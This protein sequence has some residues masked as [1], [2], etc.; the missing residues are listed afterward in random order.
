M[1]PLP[2]SLRWAQRVFFRGPRKELRIFTS[3]V[4]LILVV[5]VRTFRDDGHIPSRGL[6]T[7]VEASAPAWD[8][9][10]FLV[11]PDPSTR[12]TC[13]SAHDYGP[14]QGRERER[15]LEAKMHENTRPHARTHAHTRAH[16]RAH[17]HIIAHVRAGG[18]VCTLTNQPTPHLSSHACARIYPVQP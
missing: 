13:D 3:I 1:R 7:T 15:P 5:T 4:M 11:D 18:C 16:T 6:G 2:S 12:L 10:A 8:S 14:G 9:L 17:V